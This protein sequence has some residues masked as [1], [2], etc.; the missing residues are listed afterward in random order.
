MQSSNETKDLC[1][2][3]SGELHPGITELEFHVESQW[4]ICENLPAQICGQCG[5]AY[6]SAQV[7]HQIDEILARRKQLQPLRYETVPVFSPELIAA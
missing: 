6:F 3:C 4:V 5:E 7:S 1:D 2:F